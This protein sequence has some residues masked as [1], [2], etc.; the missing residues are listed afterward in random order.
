MNHRV[1]LTRN[2]RM[3]SSKDA[4][5]KLAQVSTTIGKFENLAAHNEERILNNLHKGGG[6]GSRKRG[7]QKEPLVTV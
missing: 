4:K 6:E 7:K 2:R 1:E 5:E 3:K